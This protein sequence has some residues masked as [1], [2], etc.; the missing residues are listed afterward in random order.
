MHSRTM[1]IFPLIILLTLQGCMGGSLGDLFKDDPKQLYTSRLSSTMYESKLRGAWAG[2]MIGLSFAQPYTFEYQGQ[3]M[4]GSVRS[5]RPNYVSNALS[6]D[7]MGIALSFLDALEQRRFAIEAED[8]GRIFSKTTFP[9][10]GAADAARTNVRSGIM[11]PESAH[12]RYNPYAEN[13][14][15]QA[16]ADLFGLICPGMPRTAIKMAEQFADVMSYGDGKNG[17]FYIAGM[18][19]AAFFQNDPID[20][21]RTGLE[22][23]PRKSD[24]A[25]MIHDI[26]AC[27]E[28]D[29]EDWRKCWNMLEQNWSQKDLDPEGYQEAKNN[30]ALLNGGYVTM[31]LLYGEGDFYRTMLLTTLCGQNSASNSGQA[32]GILGAILGY[33]Q[34]PKQYRSGIPII[35]GDQFIGTNYNFNSLSLACQQLTTE[36]VRRR[37]GKLEQLGERPYYSVPTQEAKPYKYYKP[38]TESMANSYREEW[39]NLPQLRLERR[40]AILQEQIK[41]FVPG[42]SIAQCGAG[43]YVGYL[44]EYHGRYDVFATYPLDQEKP[45]LLRWSGT[46]PSE[47][48]RLK[49]SVAS[50]EANQ[51]ADW[52]FRAV[53]NDETLEQRTIGWMDGEVYW[54][55]I[56]LDLSSFAGQEV[57]IQLEN[58]AD[59]EMYN[60]AYWGRM[61]IEAEAQSDE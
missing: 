29:P 59:D 49:L 24:Y 20:I 5:W 42:W 38:F 13:I 15:F 61:K 4:D 55:S 52:I 26:L 45:C 40:M 33:D 28:E 54:H 3:I 44:E 31:G 19:S 7:D 2:K 50:S 58:G 57:T 39:E 35:A 18:Y 36:M 8:A 6:E 1:K 25:R 43:D 16:S 23:L 37:G 30:S 56:D 32:A 22:C 27:Y 47:N 41:D 46:L 51:D 21:V 60:T 53:V 34:I 48:P 11:P 9:T 17:G 12:P 10:S 14:D